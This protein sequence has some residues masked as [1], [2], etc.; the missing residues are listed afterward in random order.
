[1]PATDREDGVPDP[2]SSVQ[3][4]A[5]QSRLERL[6]AGHTMQLSPAQARVLAAEFAGLQEASGI[7]ADEAWRKAGW[8]ID[9]LSEITPALLLLGTLDA[10]SLRVAA[11]ARRLLAEQNATAGEAALE[12]ASSL[13]EALTDDLGFWCRGSR[14]LRFSPGDQA[15]AALVSVRWLLT[16]VATRAMYPLVAATADAATKHVSK[17]VAFR[18]VAGLA[19]QLTQG[20]SAASASVGLLVSGVEAQRR[21]G[22]SALLEL[23]A[24]LMHPALAKW[25]RRVHRADSLKECQAVALEGLVPE[26]APP[27]P[28]AVALRSIEAESRPRLAYRSLFAEALSVA[29]PA[30]AMDG[31]SPVWQQRRRMPAALP[32]AIAESVSRLHADLEAAIALRGD[33]TAMVAALRSA[34][35]GQDREVLSALHP[36]K[37]GGWHSALTLCSRAGFAEA[38]RLLLE[39]GAD[40][41]VVR[42]TGES[43]W[44]CAV[45]A[46]A[47]DE[48]AGAEA[49]IEIL[50]R[51]AGGPGVAAL[52]PAA[53]AAAQPAPGGPV[54]AARSGA[55][56]LLSLLQ[57]GTSANPAATPLAKACNL[58]SPKSAAR[59]AA[60]LVRAGAQAVEGDGLARLAGRLGIS[61]QQA[62]AAAAAPAAPAGPHAAPV[63]LQSFL[64]SP[65]LADCWIVPDSGATAEGA[66]GP[67]RL[68][69]HKVVLCAASQYFRSMFCGGSGD[70]AWAEA[71]SGDVSA[72]GFSEKV[73]RL[74]LGA[75]YGRGLP[76]GLGVDTLAELGQ[77]ASLWGM[78]DLESAVE[79]SLLRAVAPET[80]ASAFSYATASSS[81]HL[82]RT[83]AGLMLESASN[84]EL[85]APAELS[86]ALGW[87]ASES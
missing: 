83:A 81:K 30:G 63:G 13:V 61:A 17:S 5:V 9:G 68:A 26:A 50:A 14:S 49:V 86:A 58:P 29:P 1:M 82:A 60:A 55:E 12:A 37:D 21:G 27:E 80:A 48:G 51:A 31:A 53:A 19:H 64:L 84:A 62:R 15:L 39:A 7:P 66:A 43:V 24:P 4:R 45:Q 56:T 76:A 77:L 16:L 2:S 35:H 85:V 41:C 54:H 20:L 11:A 8:A 59:V 69:A 75:A 46:G 38:V 28:D 72:P 42:D 22:A 70:A 87:L 23:P 47:R 32:A 6:S 10:R 57:Q 3:T 18:R 34:C 74:A 25:V 40:P 36:A 71:V 73:L 52:E 67:A 44:H 65:L 78:G 33:A 79:R